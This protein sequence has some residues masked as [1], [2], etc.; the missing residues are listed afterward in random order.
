MALH[1]DANIFRRVYLFV[2]RV[3]LTVLVV[4]N[5][6]LLVNLIYREV[7]LTSGFFAVEE[8]DISGNRRVS[9]E[10]VLKRTGLKPGQ[11]IFALDVRGMGRRLADSPWVQDVSISRVLPR[12]VEVRLQER[13]PVA[14]FLGQK[15][16]YMDYQGTLFKPLEAMER[17][18]FPVV[19]GFA[20]GPEGTLDQHSLREVL[21]FLRVAKD[22]NLLQSISEINVHPRAGL[23]VFKCWKL[24]QVWVS[25]EKEQDS[26]K[27]LDLSQQRRV[28]AR[29]DGKT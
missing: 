28:V 27:Y 29:L 15:I 1:R 18:D 6:V 14:M 13:R 3:L 16:S 19:T 23:T 5:T 7:I 25:L 21:D 24:A 9:R 20:T 22:F 11:N 17:A 12:R 26:V 4:A 10:E 2:L 8:I